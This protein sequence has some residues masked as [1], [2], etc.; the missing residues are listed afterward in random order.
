MNLSPYSVIEDRISQKPVWLTPVL[1]SPVYSLSVN[2]LGNLL[3][4]DRLN[5]SLWES[6]RFST[7]TIR[8]RLPVMFLSGSVSRYNLSTGDYRFVVVEAV[9]L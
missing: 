1:V 8:Q 4:H 9:G 5:A 2:G 3:L 6:F 7:D